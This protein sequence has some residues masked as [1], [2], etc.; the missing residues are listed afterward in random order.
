MK[1][2]FNSVRNKLLLISGGGTI[3]LLLAAGAGMFL[4]LQTIRQLS[5]GEVAQL[6]DSRATAIEIK[7]LYFQQLLEWKNTMLRITGT[8][9]QNTHW[10]RFRALEKEIEDRVSEL[11]A[12]A[13]PEIVALATRFS[14]DHRA[15]GER[16]QKAFDD[17]QVNY[18]I[19]DLE[20]AIRGS[21][22][23]SSEVLD[24][25]IA[26]VVYQIDDRARAI[27]A[28]TQRT[29][30]ISVGLMAAA[31]LL[32]FAIF[33]WM[34]R[35]QITQPAT[36]LE[37][38]LHRLA[39][40]DF[41]QPIVAMTTDE[42]GRI[43]TSAEN[44]RSDLGAL[45]KQVARSIEQVDQ[46]AETMTSATHS[47][48]DDTAST[49]EVATSTAASVEEVTGSIHSI[50][51]NAEKA[52]ELTRSGAEAS[53]LAESRLGMLARSVEESATVMQ[54]VTQTA[55]DF[56]L[57]AQQIT[58]MTQQVRDIADQTNL[59]ALNAAIE[60]ARAGEQGR[61]F[62]VVADEVRKLAEKSG[63]S[64]SQIDAITSSLGD[65]AQALEQAL[66]RGLAALESSRGSV[67]ETS[68]A[69][70]TASRSSVSAADDVSRIN[71][72]V[73]EQSTA[74][75]RIA[76]HVETIAERVATS[77]A[78]LGRM[79]G[80]TEQLHRLTDE[81]KVSIGNFRLK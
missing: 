76:R 47:V 63:Q 29:I 36:A 8:Q 58:T 13:A 6:Q 34:I 79:S 49:A 1:K 35:K 4:Q 3:L 64:A 50:S 41:G 37:A 17:Y 15:L 74:S 54:S 56:I 59:L 23:A 32:A 7:V 12:T 24:Q 48:A 43:A 80:T 57:N 19:Y 21:E 77:T 22:D 38:D 11:S 69:L 75:D 71:A 62:A 14:T 39:R 60:A 30:L 73:R 44:I 68:E 72:A 25:L 61:G 9:E 40:G 42:I 67:A 20:Q 5:S 10:N 78:S 31:C 65:Q 18:N 2:I 81:L 26:G 27:L 16:Y 45:I 55:Q 28:G 51:S 53:R 66:K 46:A 52:S 33:L 70:E